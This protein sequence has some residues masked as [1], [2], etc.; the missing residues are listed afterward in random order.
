MDDKAAHTLQIG[1]VARLSGLSVH[2]IRKWEERHAAVVPWRT[3]SGRRLYS[4][5]DVRRLGLLKRLAERGASLRELAGYSTEQ[6][7]EA[8]MAASADDARAA[9]EPVAVAVVGISLAAELE[10]L[11]TAGSRLD[12]V[13]SAEQIETLAQVLAGAS[14]DVLLMDCRTLGRE[15]RQRVRSALQLLGARG[16]VVVYRFGAT[17]ELQALRSPRVTLLRAPAAP[18]D[19]ERAAMELI[20]S[21][22]APPEPPR[23]ATG[24]PC[25]DIPAPRISAR[26]L[27]R[28]TR[29]GPRIRCECPH[30]LVDIL[31]SLRAFEQY[32]LECES[33]HPEDAELHHWLWQR[34]AHARAIFEEAIERVA[35]AEGIDLEE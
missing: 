25:Q 29:A 35:A 9:S 19:I 15:T 34:T 16:V 7:E 18:G 10:R 2:T 20:G 23:E 24:T 13:A 6:L 5:A 28:L 31:L 27:A 12:L 14:V 30:N 26:A 22:P 33:D 32:S 21:M 17:S 8:W 4:Q 3:E 11:A 1:A